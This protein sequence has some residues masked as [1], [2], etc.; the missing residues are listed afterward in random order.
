MGGVC[1]LLVKLVILTTLL[2][3]FIMLVR[4]SGNKNLTSDFTSSGRVVNI[5]GAAS[6]V[7]GLA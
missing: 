7:R 3:Y 2:V 1:L 5:H 4:G 6:F